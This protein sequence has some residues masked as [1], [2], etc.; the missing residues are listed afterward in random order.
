MRR[1]QPERHR[2][3]GGAEGRAAQQVVE[4]RKGAGQ[5]EHAAKIRMVSAGGDGLYGLSGGQGRGRRRSGEEEQV[6]RSFTRT[7]TTKNARFTHA[8]TH[9]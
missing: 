9:A 5:A 6:V 2:V 8:L 1:W 4:R 7:Q 3:D